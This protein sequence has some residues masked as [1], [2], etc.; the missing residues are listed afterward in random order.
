MKKKIWVLA[1]CTAAAVLFTGCGA[2]A[3]SGFASSAA[4]GTAKSGSAA[5]SVS[6]PAQ[7]NTATSTASSVREGLAGAGEGGPDTL[8]GREPTTSLQSVNGSAIREIAA[9]LYAKDA[10]SIYIPDDWQ[11]I[12]FSDVELHTDDVFQ[13]LDGAACYVTVAHS[14]DAVTLDEAIAALQSQGYAEQEKA[15]HTYTISQNG[16]TDSTYLFDGGDTI[17]YI[18][19]EYASGDADA[20]A[21]TRAIAESFAVNQ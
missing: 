5:T 17:W 12:A 15:Y 13:P 11:Q 16:T 4:S 1:A 18:T 14:Y 2:A 19:S 3:S 6:S 21:L 10:Y 8:V 7:S 20:A 9:S